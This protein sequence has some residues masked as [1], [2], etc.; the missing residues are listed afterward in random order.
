ML[1]EKYKTKA[2][3][4]AEEIKKENSLDFKFLLFSQ[5]MRILFSS[6]VIHWSFVHFI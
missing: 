4:I 5:F 2:L 3:D 6:I 1:M